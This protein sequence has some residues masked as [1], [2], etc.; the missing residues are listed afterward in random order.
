MKT[1]FNAP[2]IAERGAID[3]LILGAW[4]CGAFGGNPVQIANLF[5]K[6]LLEDGLGQLG[7]SEAEMSTCRGATK[8]CTLPF[9]SSL[10]MTRTMPLGAAMSRAVLR[11]RRCSVELP[12]FSFRC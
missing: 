2:H 10:R 9:R 7:G 1:I 5:V 4:G 8:R 11:L 12:R 6:A 3:T